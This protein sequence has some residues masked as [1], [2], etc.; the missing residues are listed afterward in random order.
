MVGSILL[1]PD[2]PS[3]ASP[4]SVIL[5]RCAVRVNGGRA[6]TVRQTAGVGEPRGAARKRRPEGPAA[7]MLC[8]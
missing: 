3:A 1:V 5:I 2:V 4:P 6:G 8:G 7:G